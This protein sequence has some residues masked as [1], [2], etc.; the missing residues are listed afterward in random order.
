M[1]DKTIYEK[2]KLYLGR[3]Y[4]TEAVG[5]E[6]MFEQKKDLPIAIEYWSDSIE[7]PKPTQEELDAL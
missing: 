7:K 2:V 3:D 5:V 4:N 1:S 6:V